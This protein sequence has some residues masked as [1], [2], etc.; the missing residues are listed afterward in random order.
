MHSKVKACMGSIIR[1][2]EVR[3]LV[4]IPAVLLS[5]YASISASNRDNPLYH[6]YS[7][8]SIHAIDT[9]IYAMCVNLE[10]KTGVHSGT[11]MNNIHDM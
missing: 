3:L 8:G 6:V 9:Y 5:M 11:Q 7:L 4:L 1:K 2:Q 10:D